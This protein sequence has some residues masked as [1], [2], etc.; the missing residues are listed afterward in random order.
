MSVRVLKYLF[1]LFPFNAWALT[2]PPGNALTYDVNN[3]HYTA[4]SG[5]VTWTSRMMASVMPQGTTTLS[6][7]QAF[8]PIGG[9]SSRVTCYYHVGMN[10]VSFTTSTR[11]S[12][13][14]GWSQLAGNLKTGSY[15]ADVNSCTFS[16][17]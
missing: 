1:L 16:V 17:T 11:F 3:G 7:V 5:A 6:G 9:G 8:T 14:V 12:L 10:W 15:C 2:C 13:D 4:I